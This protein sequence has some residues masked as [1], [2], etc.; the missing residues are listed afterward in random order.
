MTIL[1]TP[2]P[3][4]ARNAATP[5]L[6]WLG[7]SNKSRPQPQASRAKLPQGRPGFSARTIVCAALLVVFS[8]AV[9][10]WTISHAA[11]PALDSVSFVS[12]A[13]RF[14]R[15][16]WL[17]TLAL[18]P[19][20]PLFPML[21]N[22][23][24]ALLAALGFI[25]PQ[26]WGSSAQVASALGLVLAAPL[27]YGLFRY[28]VGSWAAMA[29]G[30]FFC[31]ITVVARSGGDG[32]SDGTQLACL[33]ASLGCT[34]RYLAGLAGRP[35][36]RPTWLL[37]AGALVGLGLLCRSEAAIVLPAVV[38]ALLVECLLMR[39]LNRTGLVLGVLAL[40]L[41]L[42][43]VVGPYL[44]V[45][46]AYS[47]AAAIE[48]LV[49]R[50]GPGDMTPLNAT[51]AEAAR[52]AAISNKPAWQLPGGRPMVFGRKDF[53]SSTRFHG[54]GS[55][56]FELLRELAQSLHYGLGLLALYGL[57]ATRAV[58]IRPIDRL[59]TILYLLYVAAAFYVSWQS[60]Y[61]AGRHLLPIVAIALP[62]AALGVWELDRRATQFIERRLPGIRLPANR[63]AAIVAGVLVGLLVVGCLVPTLAPLHASR[64]GHQQAMAWLNSSQARAGAVLDSMGLTA[65]YSGRTTYRY[66]AA[67][68]A[69][70][71][72]NLAYIVI[73]QS[74]LAAKSERGATMRAMLAQWAGLA[75]TFAPAEP[76]AKDRT[77]LVYNWQ[78]DRFAQFLGENHAR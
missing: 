78:G 10:A 1:T 8:A 74:E 40:A 45:A 42:A 60:G 25:A 2:A 54:M 47:P 37:A 61:L 31:V 59:L 28:C 56:A 14:D 67:A 33:L 21:V 20:P 64:A 62:W 50:R 46:G 3:S 17:A 49:G 18:D 71:D 35:E 63:T 52:V 48:R 70:T 39:S 30:L 27:A 65:L 19:S 66:H 38:A 26:N 22:R 12:L 11:V 29:G 75:A 53:S 13:Q 73:E 15:D 7:D 24:H 44:A 32:L 69:L 36:G 51:A 68:A 76:K 57:W 23:V 72:P 6:G 34:A 58:I 43:I 4:T 5:R 41:G 9:Q 77:V 55:A 16:G